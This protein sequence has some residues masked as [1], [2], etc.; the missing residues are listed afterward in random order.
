MLKQVQHD[1]RVF[2]FTLAEVLI[3]LVIIGV[4]AALT[5]PNLMQNYK[6]H[7]VEV[8]LK[9]AYTILSNALTMARADGAADS[10]ADMI[11]AAENAS[12]NKYDFF[13]E[14]YLIPYLKVSKTCKVGV[15]VENCGLFKQNSLLLRN[16]ERLNW[17]VYNTQEKSRIGLQNGMF[18]GVGV[19]RGG[20]AAHG[21]TFLVDINGKKGPE[22]MGYDLFLFN[23]DASPCT[24][25]NFNNYYCNRPD[26]I[27]GGGYGTS[28]YNYYTPTCNSEGY[29]CAVVIQRNSWKIPDDYPVKKF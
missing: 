13:A 26:L 21:I 1:G 15:S 11:N 10:Y 6:K 25:T 2:A 3:T 27:I 14:K 29:D 20:L 4:I 19:S 7:Q 28:L 24:N 17:Q 9:E 8:Q 18:I 12:E 5:I 22:R 23:I 16:G